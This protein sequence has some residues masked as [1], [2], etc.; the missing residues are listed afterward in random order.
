MCKQKVLVR[1][2]IAS[3]PTGQLEVSRHVSLTR[4]AV[5][6]CWEPDRPAPG[7]WELPRATRVPRWNTIAAD[8]HRY[9]GTH[10]RG[11]LRA[12]RTGQRPKDPDR[13][14]R[15][16]ARPAPGGRPGV[17]GASQS[18]PSAPGTHPPW[19]RPPAARHR[20]QH[21]VAPSRTDN[22]RATS[23]Q[24]SRCRT[25]S[26]P[27]DCRCGAPGLTTFHRLRRRPLPD[28]GW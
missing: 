4:S 6:P 12:G 1:L 28:P 11:S 24:Q 21:R 20:I 18:G 23:K 26:V 5:R 3:K 13:P 15:C 8:S 19:D 27:R 7:F 2:L 9:P 14:R 22:P 17:A 16:E 10:C 25:L